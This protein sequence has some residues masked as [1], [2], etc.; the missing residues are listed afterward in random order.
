MKE[1]F[2]EQPSQESFG[3]QEEVSIDRIEVEQDAEKHGTKFAIQKLFYNLGMC[4]IETRLFE[5]EASTEKIE[6]AFREMPADRGFTIRFSYKDALNLPRG[7]FQTPQECLEFIKKERR[8]YA[9]IVQEYTRLVNSFELYSDGNLSYLQAL[10]GIWEVDAKEAPDVVREKDGDLTIWRFRQPRQAKLINDER[11]FQTKEK[12]P[13]TLEQ[14]QEFYRKLE[15]YKDKLEAIRKIFNPLFCH[16]YEDD[17][18]RFCF[19]NLRDVEEFTINEDSPSNFCVI[20]NSSDVEKWDGGTP[21]LFDV[22]TERGDDAPLIATIESLRSKEIDSVFV[23]YGILSHPAILLREAGIQVHQSYQLY[24]KEHIPAESAQVKKEGEQRSVISTLEEIEGTE[25]GVTAEGKI[26]QVPR[27]SEIVGLD[28]IQ[29]GD[30]GIVGGKA[31]N[32]GKIANAGFLVPK[33]FVIT[34][35]AFR[36]WLDNQG[37]ISD[38]TSDKITRAFQ[39][40]NMENIAVRSSATVE[41]LSGA[42]S[43][44]VYKTTLNVKKET[45]LNSIKEGFRSFHDPN[46]E[47]YRAGKFV[48]EGAGMALV[49][50]EMIGAKVSGVIFTRNPLNPDAKEF[51]IN[52]TFG[53]GEPLTSGRI[54]G[55]TYVIDKE[56]GAIKETLITEKENILTERGEAILAE[57]IQSVPTLSEE[58]VRQL[59]QIGKEMERLFSSPQDVEFAISRDKIYVLQSR[60]ITT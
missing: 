43:A 58:Q 54:S 55:D 39:A 36:E 22:Q 19:I 59:I 44:G 24:E 49:V 38:E 23:N 13:F 34:A 40:L 33:G 4:G 32:L 51:T 52:A 31:Y 37:E 47:A 12:D 57:P 30:A 17:K 35:H 45:L 53:L 60:S 8:D 41:D 28:Q 50:Q 5:P 6:E 18:G 9:I 20:K 27:S 2:P 29:E 25:I 7:F 14:L 16:F 10:P 1:K 11:K 56:S 15:L 46:A 48:E 42:S 21:I 26:E 3:K